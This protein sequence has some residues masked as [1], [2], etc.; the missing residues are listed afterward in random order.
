[1]T[2]L[3]VIVIYRIKYICEYRYVILLTMNVFLMGSRDR[4]NF[5]LSVKPWSFIVERYIILNLHGG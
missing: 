1:M 5:L 3:F 4:L 2:R